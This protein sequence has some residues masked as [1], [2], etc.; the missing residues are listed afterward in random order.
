M[1]RRRFL[2]MTGMTVTAAALRDVPLAGFQQ[3]TT[4]FVDLRR[5]V[6]IFNGQG[7]RSAGW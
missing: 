4:S 6:G 5:G 7:A 3:L 1:N 2:A